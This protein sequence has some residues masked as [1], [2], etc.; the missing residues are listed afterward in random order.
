[1]TAGQA[2][3]VAYTK[4]GTTAQ[5]IKG[6]GGALA[7]AAASAVVNNVGFLEM[8]SCLVPYGGASTIV[9]TMNKAIAVG[10]ATPADFRSKAYASSLTTA[11]INALAEATPTAATQTTKTTNPGK[12]TLTLAA[13]VTQGQI[14]KVKYTK[15]GTACQQI[16]ASA[17][18]QTKTFALTSCTNNVGVAPPPAPPAGGGGAAGGASASSSSSYTSAAASP[19]PAPAHF[20][21]AEIKLTGITVAQFDATAKANFKSVI[22]AGM[23][24]VTA[25]DV[26]D[27]TATAATRRSGVKVSFKVKVAT[28]A[29]ASSGATTLNTF[30]SDTTGANGFL[31]KLKAQG[32][33][34]A[35]VSG[36]VVTKAPKAKTSVTVSGVANTAILSLMSFLALSCALLH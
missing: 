5:N 6:N 19:A 17:T 30:L 21:E 24:G 2:V 9:L 8:A 36:V 11:Q 33:A 28:A 10:A 4:S 25:T 14:V 12:I 16:G 15:S 34:L 23:T 3:T 35:N 22:A 18:T 29:A 32:G 31:T 26:Y 13:A 27:V 1:V 7:T 20:I